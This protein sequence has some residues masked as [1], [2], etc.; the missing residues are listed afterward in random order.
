MGTNYY[1]HKTPPCATCGHQTEGLHIG[2]SSGGWVFSLRVY[3]DDEIATLTDW[4]RRWSQPG[5]EIRNEYGELISPEQMLSDITKRDWPKERQWDERAL[6]ANHAVRGPNG[7]VRH[8]VGSLCIG[9]GPGTYDYMLGD[10][11]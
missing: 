2:K 7:L 9:H 5:S 3:P 6:V 10:F 11:S 8:R 4:Q 1:W